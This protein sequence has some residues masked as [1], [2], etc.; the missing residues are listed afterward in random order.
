[1]LKVNST[2]TWKKFKLC[3]E[4]TRKTTK[5]YHWRRFAALLVNFKHILQ[6]ALLFRLLTW[7]CNAV[8][9]CKNIFIVVIKQ[10][11]NNRYSTKIVYNFSLKMSVSN[12]REE[13]S[14]HLSNERCRVCP[15]TILY[16]R[17]YNTAEAAA[18][19]VPDLTS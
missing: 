4:L 14:C 13:M 9:N 3:S 17:F 7:A 2:N 8:R 6:L 15:Q 10:N 12:Q 1:M 19:G 5:W 11:C 16:Y 18:G